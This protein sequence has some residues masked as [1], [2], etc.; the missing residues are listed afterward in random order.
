[1]QNP[2]AVVSAVWNLHAEA[3]D[4]T[5]YGLFFFFAWTYGSCTGL[6]GSL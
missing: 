5:A 1:M 4:R 3:G 6:I 2:S